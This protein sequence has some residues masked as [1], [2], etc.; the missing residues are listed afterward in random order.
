MPETE[1][2]RT[3]SVGQNVAA[4]RRRRGLTLEGLAEISSV[5]RASI[6]SLENGADNPRIQTLWNLA[7][8][9]GVNFG[10]L[11]GESEREKILNDD[12]GSV[13]L[14]ERQTSPKVI[15]AY[16]LELPAGIDRKAK[17]HVLGVYEHVIVLAGELLTGPQDSPSLLSPGQSMSFAADV[18]HTYSA[19]NIRARAIVTV[20]YP[21]L[22]D[23]LPPDQELNWPQ[24]Q[25]E[26]ESVVSL[27]ARTAI[28]VQNGIGVSTQTFCLPT[29]LKPKKA[30]SELAK[31][32]TII[33]R[34]P[35]IRRFIISDP[36]PGILSLYRTP[37]LQRLPLEQIA[38]EWTRESALPYCNLEQIAS[39]WTRESAPATGPV[40][41]ELMKRCIELA[42]LAT[43]HPGTY[44]PNRLHDIVGKTS[45]LIESALAAEILTQ[46]GTPTV[47]RGVGMVAHSRAL[48]DTKAERLF[49]DRIYVD[50]YEAYELVHPAYARQTLA[51]ACYLPTQNGL[52]ILDVGTGPGLPLAMLRELRPDMQALA[53]DPSQAAV[54]HLMRRFADD[55]CVEIQQVSITELEQRNNGFEAA[56]SIGASHH[57]DTSAFL[58]AIREQ[59]KHG[60]RVL[61]AD[62]MISAFSRREEREAN[63]IRH[64]LW[65]IL[66]TLV[67]VPNGAHRGDMQLAQRLAEV[68][69]GTMGMACSERSKAAR[70]TIRNLFE[71]V[72]AI[73][74]PLQPSHPLAVFS[75]FHLL[76]LQALIAG[77]DYEVEQKTSPQRFKALARM[78]G[79]EITDHHR[80]YAT[81]GDNPEDGGTHL[82]V[83]AAV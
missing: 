36:A 26:W 77:F 25:A 24:S 28:E 3:F 78:N 19:G 30:T 63:L 31:K 80:I 44:D 65:Y 42:R 2:S 29:Q 62:E 37:Q 39:E 16:M 34:T 49:E 50:A 27:M 22:E 1:R 6:S 43:A 47:P 67:E 7:D 68:L 21:R 69:P 18:P 59:T 53:V 10:T 66:D 60:G 51:L 73:E 57:L 13:Q 75:R 12:G 11:I 48:R 61:I 82:F 56:V 46:A 14:I 54:Q 33:P 35:T 52:K 8:A 83:M 38:S 41:C 45:S 58:A 55:P 81:D 70:D 15:E 76:E 20:V 9:L 72:M 5:S 40:E 17:P 79:F 32:I 74:R 64:H 4:I 23:G 71:E